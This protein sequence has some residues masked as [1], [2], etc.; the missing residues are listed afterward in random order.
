MKLPNVPYIKNNNTNKNETNLKENG[1]IK[2]RA[3]KYAWLGGG[4]FQ[5]YPLPLLWLH[6]QDNNS[7]TYN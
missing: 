1:K 3:R 6:R 2:G 7:L 5:N 4:S